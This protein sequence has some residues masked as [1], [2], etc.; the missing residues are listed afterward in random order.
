[1]NPLEAA[2]RAGTKPKDRRPPWQWIEE[3]VPIAN[4]PF[5]NRANFSLT[6]WLKEPSVCFGDNSYHELTLQCCVQGAKSFFMQTHGIWGLCE[7]PGPLGYYVQTDN[8]VGKTA[9]GRWLP[10]VRGCAPLQRLLRP[11]ERFSVGRAEIYFAHTFS[12]IMAA[13]DSNTQTISLRYV[14]C[15]DVFVWKPGML[16]Q[17]HARATQWWNRR[18]LNASTAGDK[19]GEMDLAHRGGDMRE[20]PLRCPECK[21]LQIP[22]GDKHLKWPTNEI[23]KPKGKWNYDAL[24]RA[25]RFG[26]EHCGVL[27]P[28]TEEVW[29]KMIGHDQPYIRTNPNAPSDRASFRWN[30]LTLRPSSYSWGDY[31]CDFLQATRALKA[32][33]PEPMRE[34]TI[35]RDAKSWDLRSVNPFSNLPVIDISEP[36][37]EKKFWPLQDFLLMGVDVQADHFWVLVMA[38]SKAG[39]ECA[40]F[41]KQVWGWDDIELIQLD[42]GILHEDVAIDWSHRPQEVIRECAKRGRWQK[43]PDGK[44]YWMSWRAY[45]GSPDYQFIYTQQIGKGK[46]IRTPLPYKWPPP[47]GNPILGLRADNP[48]REELRGK[49]VPI[50]IWSNPSIKDIVLARRDGRVETKVETLRGDWNK[51][52][53][54]QCHSQKKVQIRPRYGPSRWT[55]ENFTDDHLLD[56]RCECTV[57]AIQRGLIQDVIC[58]AGDLAEG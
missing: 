58:G 6:P 38:F 44:E 23:T 53:F 2:A 41:A 52:Y 20:W 31:A 25:V 51:E 32:G 12:Y 39:D 43:E 49:L 47:T 55:Y 17:A 4:S 1:M 50:V 13:N 34:F 21:R 36:L 26:C 46:E 18:I 15:D 35:K 27:L 3:N 42:H 57:R 16:A 33:N 54:R 7:D 22:E 10:M 14:F 29:Q 19:D 5:G 8:F 48:L 40:V 30:A 28:H 45:R 37:P 56:C 9:N 11:G 24:R